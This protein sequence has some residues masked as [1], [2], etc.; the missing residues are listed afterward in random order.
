MD[1]WRILIE[2]FVNGSVDAPTFEREYISL[3]RTEVTRGAS[4]RFAVD[5]LFYEVDAYCADPNLRG[6]EDIG[7]EE[8]L[9]AAKKALNDWD[10]PW[11]PI[12]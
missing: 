6:T 12:P 4:I 7:E 9:L 2:T 3:H 1:P 8:L 11:P 5:Q 10:R